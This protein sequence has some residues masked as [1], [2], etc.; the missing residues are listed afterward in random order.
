MTCRECNGIGH[1]EGYQT[2]TKS[3]YRL[4]CQ[5]CF[6]TGNE[7]IGISYAGVGS[8][9]TPIAVIRQMEAIA[10]QLALKGW[11][12]RSGAAKRPVPLVPDTDSADLAF[13]R[14]CKMVGGR[15][16]IR[17]PSSSPGALADAA[18]YHPNWSA[19]NDNARALH[20][21]NSLIMKGDMFD[22]MVRFVVCWTQ[23]GAVKGGTGQALRIAAAHN[24]PVFNL[25]VHTPDQLYGWLG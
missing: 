7:M 22:D 18:L 6:N 24:V 3:N 15:N 1:H 20:A 23:G 19:C 16:V 8:R 25:A 21:R 10:M 2:Q 4:E 5:R 14:A 9:S 17:V 12:L 13:E 11:I